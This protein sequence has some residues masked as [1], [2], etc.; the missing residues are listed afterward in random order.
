MKTKLLLL[1]MMAIL[2]HLPIMSQENKKVLIVYYSWGGNTRA[3]AEQIKEQT[4]ADL[5]EIVPT[6][7]YPKDYN[8]CV[9]Q[10]K[11][12][13][14][15]NYKPALKSKVKDFSQYDF[16]FVGSPNWWSTIAPPVATFLT[17]YNFE[18]KTI[19]PFITHG[20]GGMARCES[21]MKKLCP[22]AKFTKGLAVYGRS[23]GAK[24]EVT[25]WLQEIYKK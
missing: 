9:E 23:S 17:S 2:F 8:A 18:G 22:K 21:D 6:E 19:A 24:K 1:S 3:V 11:K 10:A 16:I 7:A 15:E 12:E 5:F 25:E 14:R 13:I 20:G 4:G